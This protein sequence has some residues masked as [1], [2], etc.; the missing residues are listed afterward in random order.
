MDMVKLLPGE[1]MI[2]KDKNNTVVLDSHSQ[3]QRMKDAFG[4]GV[5]NPPKLDSTS[6]NNKILK[7]FKKKHLQ[8]NINGAIQY[9]Q[10]ITPGQINNIPNNMLMNMMNQNMGPG[11]NFNNMGMGMN[12]NNLNGL[13]SFNGLNGFNGMN[14]SLNGGLNGFQNIGNFNLNNNAENFALNNNKQ[15]NPNAVLNQIQ[16]QPF[17]GNPSFMLPNNNINNANSIPNFSFKQKPVEDFSNQSNL[18]KDPFQG[19]PSFMLPNNNIN[20][21]NS[22]PN[23]SFKQKHVEDFSNQSNLQK[24]YLE[25]KTQLSK[26]MVN[27]F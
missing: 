22:I 23:F 13:N 2:Y 15:M 19:N 21:A 9:P 6:N 27:F 3:Q 24:D 10:F 17:Q 4:D 1:K 26:M 7:S 5:F 8:N 20:N 18:Q 12:L 14:N 25:M 11:M 16:Q